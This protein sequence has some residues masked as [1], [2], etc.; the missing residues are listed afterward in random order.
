MV[1]FVRVVAQVRGLQPGHDLEALVHDLRFPGQE[2]TTPHLGFLRQAGDQLG[3]APQQPIAHVDGLQVLDVVVG[4]EE[5]CRRRFQVGPHAG[6][7]RLRRLGVAIGAGEQCFARLPHRAHRK[8]RNCRCRD[9]DIGVALALGL[10]RFAVVVQGAV[11]FQRFQVASQT[12]GLDDVGRKRVRT[13]VELGADGRHHRLPGG[14]PV[15]LRVY[16]VSSGIGF[17]GATLAIPA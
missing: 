11:E 4:R 14:G 8:C 3:A 12:T 6:D 16:R 7:W 9:H 13:G 1:P 2:C 10:H 5:A 15:A 17:D